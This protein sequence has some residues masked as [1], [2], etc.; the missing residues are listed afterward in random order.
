MTQHYEEH[1]NQIV[2]DFQ[3]LLAEDVRERLQQEQ[4]DELSMMIEAAISTAVLGELE[5]VSD[6]ISDLAVMVRRRGERWQKRSTA[7]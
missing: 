2:R 1:A 7:A 5:A 4:L 6:E 3:A